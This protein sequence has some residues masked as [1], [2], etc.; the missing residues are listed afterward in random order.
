MP[1]IVLALHCQND[2]VQVLYE[3]QLQPVADS[4]WQISGPINQGLAPL[5]MDDI[6]DFY[7]SLFTSLL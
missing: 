4:D 2:R 5:S 3:V 6:L 1:D 7:Y